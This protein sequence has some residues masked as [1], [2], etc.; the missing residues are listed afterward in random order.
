[1]RTNQLHELQNWHRGLLH[2]PCVFHYCA[3]LLMT[4]VSSFVGLKKSAELPAEDEIAHK[5][6]SG[7]LLKSTFRHFT[8]FRSLS[9]ASM[10]QK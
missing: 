6:E 8:T 5:S 3:I 2:S 9:Y 4:F 10:F 7:K 1:M